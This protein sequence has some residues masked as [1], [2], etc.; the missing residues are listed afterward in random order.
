MAVNTD[1]DLALVENLVPVTPRAYLP[2]RPERAASPVDLLTLLERTDFLSGE[3][4]VIETSEANLPRPAQDGQ[5]AIEQYAPEEIRL[6]VETAQQA[7]L[8]LL[9]AFNAGWRAT[10]ENGDEIPILRANGLVR[11]LVVPAGLHVVTFAYRTP[12]LREGAI[13]SLAGIVIGLMLIA[14]TR[15]PRRKSS[16]ILPIA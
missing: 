3:V 10:L 1:Y 9:D 2:P 7:V 12:L 13:V 14:R 16:G 6:R 15:W 11:A 8:I 5:A 4:D